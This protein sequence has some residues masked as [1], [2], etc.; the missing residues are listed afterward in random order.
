MSCEKTGKFPSERD[1]TAIISIRRKNRSATGESV[2]RLRVP[3]TKTRI[4]IDHE[5]CYACGACVA[6]CPPDSLFLEQLHLSV[7]H[8][9]C[10]RCD[11]CTG[12]CPVHALTLEPWSSPGQ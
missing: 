1:T 5:K 11:R 7:D 9:T 3:Q 10:T 12:M 4:V 2:F 6:V 8:D